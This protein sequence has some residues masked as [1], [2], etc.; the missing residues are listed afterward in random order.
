MSRW[1]VAGCEQGGGDEGRMI[2]E[3][4]A[5]VENGVEGTCAMRADAYRQDI[6]AGNADAD[7]IGMLTQG[8][9]TSVRRISAES[10]V[11]GAGTVCRVLDGS[12]AG[13]PLCVA[14]HQA[15]HAA[16]SASGTVQRLRCPLG[17]TLFALPVRTGVGQIEVGPVI[18]G[19]IDRTKFTRVL[20]QL[21]LRAEVQSLLQES[22]TQLR[23]ISLG[24]V[25][26]VLALVQRVANLASAETPVCV[27]R[28]GPVEPAAVGAARQFIEV[29]LLY[30]LTL[31]GVAQQVS[32]S[33][34]HFSR[35]FRRATGGTFGEY[36]NRRRVAMAERLLGDST[37]R[38][39]EVCYASGFLSLPHFNRVFRR[40]AGV[41]PTQYRRRLVGCVSTGRD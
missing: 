32:L 37:Q 6:D 5:W 17:F 16:A 35:L 1:R 19:E 29:N 2:T 8:L 28:P 36:V 20:R 12:C 13:R 27:S 40:I 15:L 23:T 26:S 11:S 22:L 14:A 24:D 31:G 34:D 30:R 18:V 41:S 38:V 4:T 3:M 39:A 9:G 25:E 7:W 10:S 21:G 33:S